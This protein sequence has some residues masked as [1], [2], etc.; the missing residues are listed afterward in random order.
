LY[1]NYILSFAVA[2]LIHEL[3]HFLAARMC[4]VTASELG[5]GWGPRLFGIRVRGVEY[6]LHALPIGA[7]VRLDMGQLQRRPLGQQLFVLMAGILVNL[8]AG[9][10]AYGT[11]FGVINLLLAIGN[12]LPVYQQDGWKC[13]MVL[14]RAY[15]NR[16]SPLVE[17]TFTLV[18]GG[19]T[20]IV[21]FGQKLMQ[22]LGIA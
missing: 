13:G 4:R 7:Y 16:K 5:L 20:L 19:G 15:F 14:V 9:Y 1:A 18:G 12:I 6:K 2:L 3:G 10:A 8:V 11:F 21:L 22:L 17:W